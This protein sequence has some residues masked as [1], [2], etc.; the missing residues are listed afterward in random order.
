M[1]IAID[2]PTRPEAAAVIEAHGRYTSDVSP[3]NTC[4]YL[5]ASG[6]THPDITFWT[7][8]EDGAVLGCIAL[9]M[10][11]PDRA[12]IKSMHV[13]AAHRGKGIARKL[14]EALI[15][16]ARGRG[17]SWLGLE[18][19]RSEGFAA[20]RA[21]YAKLGFDPCEPFGAYCGKSF[22]YCM[23]RAL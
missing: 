2:E 13:L 10:L 5:D 23:S 8:Q 15:E 22:S 9:K 1:R 3:A 11:S 17:V 20:S 16:E 6:L 7:A 18:T 4:H 19:G 14:I 12:E 21:L